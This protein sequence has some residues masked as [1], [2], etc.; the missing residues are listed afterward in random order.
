M[1]HEMQHEDDTILIPGCQPG[2]LF[3]CLTINGS[4]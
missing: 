3:L 1:Q 4:L 2:N